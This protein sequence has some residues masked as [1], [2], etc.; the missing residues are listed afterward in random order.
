[1]TRFLLLGKN[2]QVGHELQQLLQ[3]EVVSFGREEIDLTD[4]ASI[5]SQIQQISPD[6]II[7][8]AAYTAVDRAE[9]E[10]EQAFLVNAEA[11]G[12]IAEEAKKLDAWLI[13]YSTDYVFD[14][15]KGAPY[16]EENT[17][18]PLNVYGLSKL[19]GEEAVLSVGGRALILRTS[20]VYG[21][22]GS[23]FLLTMQKLAKEQKDLS[24]V[25]D[26]IG[27]PTWSREVARTTTA[28]AEQLVEG[29]ELTGIYHLAAEGQTSWY[30]FAKAIFELLEGTTP[31][32]SP[33][34]STEYPQK[35]KRPLFSV[36][37]KDRLQKEFGFRLPDWKESLQECLQ[38]D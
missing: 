36:L 12:I 38:N 31:E 16:T 34:A 30:G 11:P 15:K 32:L 1:M 13:H 3:G 2:G 26:Q 25:D 18:N 29:K 4:S 17:P 20:W 33:I 19:K 21:C 22:R 14:G 37:S 28:I 10:K 35:A 8:A 7:N 5:R 6:V 27:S 23:N 9:E 24:I